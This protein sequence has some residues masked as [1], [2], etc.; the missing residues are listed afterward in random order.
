MLMVKGE[1]CDVKLVLHEFY[2]KEVASNA[3]SA[4][5]RNY[6]RTILN[7]VENF[8]PIVAESFPGK[9]LLVMLTR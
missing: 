6:K 3:R 1:R 5:P 4:L 7:T 2:S 9:T 8:S